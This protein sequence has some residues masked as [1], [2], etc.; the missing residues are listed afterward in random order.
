MSY[1]TSEDGN[2]V[3]T[4]HVEYRWNVLGRD[5]LEL[6]LAQHRL[7]AEVVGEGQFG[8]FRIKSD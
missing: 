6:E 3:D 5:T 4:M 2:E 8:M 7:H 1:T